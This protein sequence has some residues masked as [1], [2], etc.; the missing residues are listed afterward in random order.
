MHENKNHENIGR[1][2]STIQEKEEPFLCQPCNLCFSSEEKFQD[3][4]QRTHGEVNNK[5]D[6]YKTSKAPEVKDP[7]LCGP[8]NIGFT[9]KEAFKDHITSV[10]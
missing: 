7:F 10:H 4:F 8:C 1:E 9:S 5:S 2:F 3:H 6:D